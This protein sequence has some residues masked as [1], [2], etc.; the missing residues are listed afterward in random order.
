MIQVAEG[1]P[2]EH[3]SF[4]D[5]AA[6]R[7]FGHDT[8]I[9]AHAQAK[10]G[11]QILGRRARDDI[12]RAARGIA[13][14]K[15]ALRPAQNL[16]TLDVVKAAQRRRRA[17]D[18]DAIGMKS[19]AA[20]RTG[21]DV[22]KTDPAK[23]NP[24]DAGGVADIEVRNQALEPFQPTDPTCGKRVA[25]HRRHGGRDVLNRLGALLSGYDDVFVG[26]GGFIG[27]GLRK[28][29]RRAAQ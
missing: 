23:R 18:E 26:R 27:A 10:I 28:C 25:R 20:L 5:R 24:R 8:V 9:V 29:A 3:R 6:D 11:A 4:D 21:T 13:S 14:V 22:F 1:K 19:D 12:D 7:A 2:G 15:R 16:D 17:R